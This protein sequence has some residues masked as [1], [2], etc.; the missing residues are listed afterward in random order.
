MSPKTQS[1]IQVKLSSYVGNGM[2]FRQAYAK[3]RESPPF[4]SHQEISRAILLA[5]DSEMMKLAVTKE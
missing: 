1:D 5:L 3:L 2:T 4:F